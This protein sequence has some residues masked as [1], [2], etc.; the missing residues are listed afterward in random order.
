VHVRSL[1]LSVRAS[2]FELGQKTYCALRCG[3]H[4]PS[5]VDV[6]DVDRRAAEQ[7]RL[8]DDA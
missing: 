1:P 2:A 3:D 4:E 7:R 8:I 6:D 5:R